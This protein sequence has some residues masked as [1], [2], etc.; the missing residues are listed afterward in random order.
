MPKTHCDGCCELFWRY[1]YWRQRDWFGDTWTNIVMELLLMDLFSNAPSSHNLL[2]DPAFPGEKVSKAG[3]P[4]TP[5]WS[6]AMWHCPPGC[7]LWDSV[8]LNNALSAFW[9]AHLILI[10]CNNCKVLAILLMSL[11][12]SDFGRMTNLNAQCAWSLYAFCHAAWAIDPIVSNVNFIFF[13][14]QPH[15]I[16]L[17]TIYYPVNH[18]NVRFISPAKMWRCVANFIAHIK[19]TKRVRWCGRYKIGRIGFQG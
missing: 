11:A 10:V 15:Q 5:P 16:L 6:Q 3:P 9:V 13:F 18:F 12:A 8:T 7:N 4:P 17:L 2:I 19:T 14:N 1:F